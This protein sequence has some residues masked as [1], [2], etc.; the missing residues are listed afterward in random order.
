MEIS[1]LYEKSYA[2]GLFR[3]IFVA[4]NWVWRFLA[5]ISAIKRIMGTFTL[6]KWVYYFLWRSN[7]RKNLIYGIKRNIIN[8]RS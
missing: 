7:L 3:M 4:T 1:N 5:A 2:F 6:G 8:S